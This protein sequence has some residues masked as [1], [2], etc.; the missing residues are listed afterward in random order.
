V[1]LALVVRDQPHILI[2]YRV[3]DTVD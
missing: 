1:I 2:I 3:I